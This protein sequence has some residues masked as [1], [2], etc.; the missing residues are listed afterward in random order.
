[1]AT[2]KADSWRG[3]LAV[4][5]LGLV[6]PVGLK[7]RPSC[8][9]LRAGVSRLESLPDL[10]IRVNENELDF[11]TGATV[12]PL[13]K[14]TLG[15]DRLLQMMRPAFTEAL[16]D[17]R[18]ESQRLGVF[19]GTSGSSPAGRVLSYD[20]AVRENLLASVPDL[21]YRPTQH[22]WAV[23]SIIGRGRSGVSLPALPGEAGASRRSASASTGDAA[24]SDRS[25]AVR[26]PSTATAPR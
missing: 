17:S 3:T 9:A 23:T 6:T 11:V 2:Q 19:L 24:I 12:S 26:L 15:P 18:L 4:T 8:A 5:G 21:F 7:A 16:E 14:G 13:T 20:D 1:M 22:E 25:L 10:M